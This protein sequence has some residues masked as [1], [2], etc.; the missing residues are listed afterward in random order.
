M[1]APPEEASRGFEAAGKR[2]APGA[3]APVGPG[4]LPANF[5]LRP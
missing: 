1:V 4:A 2:G 3:R 5:F